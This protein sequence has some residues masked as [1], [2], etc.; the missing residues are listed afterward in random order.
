M[1]CGTLGEQ[2]RGV[3]G[4][5]ESPL[6]LREHLEQAPEVLLGVAAIVSHVGVEVGRVDIE[7]CLRAVSPS[8]DGQGVSTEDGRMLKS[9]G[10]VGC[11]G[12]LATLDLPGH[13]A[14]HATFPCAAENG[15]ERLVRERPHGPCAADGRV[16]L[17]GTVD[18]ASLAVGVLAVERAVDFAF[19]GR[20]VRLKDAVEVCYLT[21]DVV[22]ELHWCRLLGPKDR[23]ASE[24]GFYVD[25]VLRDHRQDGAEHFLFS[26][27]IGNRRLHDWFVVSHLV[28][29]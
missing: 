5:H 12:C 16:S 10:V 21:V 17:R 4:K 2:L 20:V 15:V 1:C 18:G 22:D 13:V 27:V 11:E 6:D 19:Q 28:V 7:E 29:V 14:R 3:G 25:V 23:T 24:E 8:D 26:A 9:A